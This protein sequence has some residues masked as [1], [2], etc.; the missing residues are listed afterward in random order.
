MLGEA[1]RQP[2][3][4]A[5][6]GRARDPVAG[7]GLYSFKGSGYV[8]GGLFDRIVLIQGDMS[9]R[10]R[11]RD[12]RRLG[13]SPPRARR[14]SPRLDLFKI[15]ADA[16]FDPTEPW[17][18]QLLV[19][20][21]V[22]AIERVFTT[23]DLGYQLP[24]GYPA[25]VARRRRCRRRWHDAAAERGRADGAVAAHL[26][27]QAVEIAGLVRDAGRAD[28]G[29]L[30]PGLP[31]PL[32]PRHLLVPHGLPDVTLVFLGWYANA[33]LSVVNLMALAGA[34]RRAS[35]GRPSCWIR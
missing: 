18:L 32:E 23:F 28:G 13:R 2:R 3:A 24:S 35:A 11:D 34:A 16:G 6:R 31:H 29:V 17:R 19:Q 22:A 10:F 7:R 12:H 33:Q 4:L 25:R 9:V 5:R 30:L 26:A 14:S 1:R 21:D 20:R 8:R 27:R 15:P